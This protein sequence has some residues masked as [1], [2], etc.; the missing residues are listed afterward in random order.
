[1]EA[2]FQSGPEPYLAFLGIMLAFLV[3]NRSAM[4]KQLETYVRLN[5]ELRAEN[6][7]L[8]RRVGALE[9]SLRHAGIPIY[10]PDLP[11]VTDP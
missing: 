2:I 3:G 11:N 4:A 5:G 6:D 8:K 7:E 9:A 10:P 1:M